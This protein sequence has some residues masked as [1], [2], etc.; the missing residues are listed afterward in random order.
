M[1]PRRSIGF[2]HVLGLR[3]KDPY[4]CLAIE[5]ENCIVCGAPAQFLCMTKYGVVAMYHLQRIAQAFPD[6][7][8]ARYLQ[9]FEPPVSHAAVTDW[10]ERALTH[11]RGSS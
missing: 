11:E 5:A 9:S 3:V 1:D 10:L 7:V 6:E 2:K 4:R 8:K